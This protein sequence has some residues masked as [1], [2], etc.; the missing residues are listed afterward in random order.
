MKKSR[1][2]AG[3]MSLPSTCALCPRQQSSRWLKGRRSS[4]PLLRY[5]PIPPKRFHIIISLRTWFSE[6]QPL[7]TGDRRL[8]TFIFPVPAEVH[9]SAPGTIRLCAYAAGGAEVS[10]AVAFANGAAR[11]LRLSYDLEQSRALSRLVIQW[12]QAAQ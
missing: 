12:Q 3:R 2:G 1:G 6:R 7:P 8:L 11:E 9:W 5:I 4:S 10:G